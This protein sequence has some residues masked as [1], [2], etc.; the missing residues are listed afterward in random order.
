MRQ[1]ARSLAQRV[2]AAVYSSASETFLFGPPALKMNANG[3]TTRSIV[4]S[5]SGV[6]AYPRTLEDRP[7]S[8]FLAILRSW[9][10]LEAL[11]YSITLTTSLLSCGDSMHPEVRDQLYCVLTA[12]ASSNDRPALKLVYQ[13][14]YASLTT[15]VNTVWGAI[16]K[17]CA[18]VPLYQ[19]MTPSALAVR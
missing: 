11:G 12:G 17:R 1:R 15:S 5:P 4:S 7:A 8:A 14:R 13:R 10:R 9:H 3:L 19:P 6:D 2:Q 16:R 18:V